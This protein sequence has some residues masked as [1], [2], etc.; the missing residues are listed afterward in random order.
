MANIMIE[1]N[2]DLVERKYLV[3][4]DVLCGYTDEIMGLDWTPWLHIYK[5]EKQLR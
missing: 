4:A 2:C 3:E 1:N 5:E